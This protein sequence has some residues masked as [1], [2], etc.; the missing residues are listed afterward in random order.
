MRTRTAVKIVKN[1]TRYKEK[2]GFWPEPMSK[3]DHYNIIRAFKI[4]NYKPGD[5]SFIK[6]DLKRTALDHDYKVINRFNAWNL[7]RNHDPCD[8]FVDDNTGGIWDL[9]YFYMY[10]YHTKE[11]IKLSLLELEYISKNGW[12]KYVLKN[13]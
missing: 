5:F 12:D 8:E 2:W 13:M 9:I 11:T 6:N 10:F 3:R 4:I 7:L 1:C